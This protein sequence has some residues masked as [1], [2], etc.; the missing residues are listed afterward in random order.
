MNYQEEYYRYKKM[1]QNLKKM[2][3][4][5]GRFL[6]PSYSKGDGR[7]VT[8]DTIPNGGSPHD[9][10]VG[11]SNQCMLISISDFL[12]RRGQNVTVANL[13]S[14][15][16]LDD[17]TS[18]VEFNDTIPEYREAIIKIARH[19]GIRISIYNIDT[20]S[21][22]TKSID[23]S[24][25]TNNVNKIIGSNYY[26]FPITTYTGTGAEGSDINYTP[27]VQANTAHIFHDP[28]GI[29]HF[30]LIRSAAYGETEVY[31]L[32]KSL[33]G[34]VPVVP[35]PVVSPPVDSSP[36]VKP[37][38]S[39]TGVKPDAS[40]TIV[41]PPVDSSPGVKPG[42]SP[43]IVA[44]PVVSPSGAK[45]DASSTGVKPGASPTIVAPSVVSPSG[46]KPDASPSVII[47]SVP[48]VNSVTSGVG[49]NNNT[50]TTVSAQVVPAQVVPA[51]VVPAQVVPAKVNTI[52]EI[53]AELTK[54]IKIIRDALTSSDSKE[55]S[56][57]DASINTEHILNICTYIKEQLNMMPSDTRSYV[58]LN[59][60]QTE[61]TE[62]YKKSLGLD[63]LLKKGEELKKTSTDPSQYQNFLTQ[64]SKIYKDFINRQCMVTLVNTESALAKI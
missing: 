12:K 34:F 7:K 31:N 6:L 13:R 33:I 46:V 37:D 1:Y 25:V 64:L 53:K 16:G 48:T 32:D 8:V 19:F 41:A 61:F 45:P 10:E 55:H 42:A 56:I 18:T 63:K 38:A 58:L 3:Q 20:S 11:Y 39:S 51:Q 49:T 24:S 4:M 22:G 17:T 54:R 57:L 60:F 29:G 43:T 40:P 47:P 15:G 50:T 44:P 14:I 59:G 26:L 5:G 28:T 2:N 35:P 9:G 23:Q 30:E 52:E 36:G 27:E 21:S 62:L